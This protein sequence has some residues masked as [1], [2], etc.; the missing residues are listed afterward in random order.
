MS[1]DSPRRLAVMLVAGGAL[2]Q[3]A[4]TAANAQTLTPSS[5]AAAM[6]PGASIAERLSDYRQ[7]AVAPRLTVP[8]LVGKVSPRPVTVRGFAQTVV[9]GS[10]VA[11]DGLAVGSTLEARCPVIPTGRVIVASSAIVDRG[12]TLPSGRANGPVVVDC[13]SGKLGSSV[14]VTSNTVR[15]R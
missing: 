10:I 3:G 4:A 9:A 5:G 11:N 12:V 7:A 1:K 8:Q 13:R 6:R 2:L 15:R 14:Q